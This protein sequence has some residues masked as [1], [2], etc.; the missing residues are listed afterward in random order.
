M[1]LKVCSRWC[2]ALVTVLLASGASAE[3]RIT[4]EDEKRARQKVG[5][6]SWADENELTRKARMIENLGRRHFGRS[7]RNDKSD[8]ELLQRIA[9][10]KLI[11]EEDTET[12]Q[13]LGVVLGNTL[14]RELALEWKVYNDELGRSRALCVPDTE[15]C[16][17]PMTMLSRRLEVGLPVNVEAVYDNA[18]ATIDPYIPDSNAYDGVKPDPTE[19][20]KWIQDRKP[21]PPVRIR[22]Q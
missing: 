8:L 20:P 15:H 9:D 16:L 7:L 19:R 6:L 21:K 14:R 18:V 12:L 10:Q 2:F 11:K 5:E 4:A 3:I 1:Q 17:F 13:A 22:I